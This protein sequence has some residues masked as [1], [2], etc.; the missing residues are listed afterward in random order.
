MLEE[1]ANTLPLTI[2]TRVSYDPNVP[3]NWGNNA[4]KYN[5]VANVQIGLLPNQIVYSIPNN[6]VL[7]TIGQMNYYGWGQ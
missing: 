2:P 1:R 6:F 5:Q 4:T 7:Y 3:W